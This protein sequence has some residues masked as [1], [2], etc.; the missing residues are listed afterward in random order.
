MKKDRSIEG[1]YSVYRNRDAATG[2]ILRNEP[3]SAIIAKGDIW[4]TYR[5]IGQKDLEAGLETRSSVSLLKL[6]FDCQASGK[7]ICG[8]WMQPIVAGKEFEDIVG[9]GSFA[10]LEET[11]KQHVLLLPAMQVGQQRSVVQFENLYYCIGDKWTERDSSGKF[12]PY[13]INSDMFQGWNNL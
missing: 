9:F 11:V 3:L 13:A 5:P 8:C 1:L 4:L 12:V 7:E 2:A 6:Y 10:M